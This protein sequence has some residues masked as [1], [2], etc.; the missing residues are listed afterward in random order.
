MVLRFCNTTRLL[1]QTLT[2]SVHLTLDLLLGHLVV[3]Q[4]YTQLHTSHFQS[5]LSFV[6]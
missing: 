5:P 2:Q 3:L 6:L 4:T 1:G